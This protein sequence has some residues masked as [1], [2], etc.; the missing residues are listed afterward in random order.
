MKRIRVMVAGAGIVLFGFAVL[1]MSGIVNVA[2]NV[3]PY[4]LTE[5]LWHIA[6]RQSVTL[7]S[8]V[9]NAPPLDNPDMIRRA[10]G[11]YELVCATCHGSPVRSPAA[12]ARHILPRPP[13]LVLQMNRWRPP[14]RVFWTVKHGIRHTAMPAWPDQLRD[15]EVWDMAAFLRALP[16]MSR[17]TYRALSGDG[18]SSMCARCHGANGE[19]GGSGLPRLDIQSPAYLE[20][21]LRAFRDG[22]RT[23]GIMQNIADALDDH[24]IDDLAARYGRRTVA[25]KLTETGTGADIALRG[26]PDRRIPACQG[27]HGPD[28]RIDY[29]S[30][31]GQ[32]AAYIEQQLRLFAKLGAQRGGRHAEIMATA[33]SGLSTDEMTAVAAWYAGRRSALPGNSFVME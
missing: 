6:V 22:S 4:A 25:P 17:D 20:A 29:P 19:G 15:D 27:C 12:Y 5:W 18:A 10:A 21:A 1:A 3:Q 32:D 2:A 7:R 30:L 9:I 28:A 13:H 23:S 26:I 24:A 31:A 11:H 14:A 16:E 33:V 8:I